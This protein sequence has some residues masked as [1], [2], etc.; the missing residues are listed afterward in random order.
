MHQA[1]SPSLPPRLPDSPLAPP[2][3]PALRV[4]FPSPLAAALG[5]PRPFADGVLNAAM[6]LKTLPVLLPPPVPRPPF[7]RVSPRIDIILPTICLSHTARLRNVGIA[8]F[9]GRVD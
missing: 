7:R 1:E 9:H 3:R 5:R 2:Y 4:P 6:N 8:F